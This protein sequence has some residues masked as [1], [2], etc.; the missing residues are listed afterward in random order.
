MAE[1]DL[2]KIKNGHL[3][4]IVRRIYCIVPWLRGLHVRVGRSGEVRYVVHGELGQAGLWRVNAAYALLLVV[5]HLHKLLVTE[6]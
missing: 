1:F 3:Q 2:L 5:L 6:I 4:R